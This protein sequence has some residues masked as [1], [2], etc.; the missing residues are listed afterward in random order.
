MSVVALSQYQSFKTLQRTSPIKCG[1]Y[2]CEIAAEGLT[3]SQIAERVGSDRHTVGRYLKIGRWDDE[4][5]ELAGH[6]NIS[7][8]SIIRAAS[9]PW[10]KGQ[11]IQYL[12]K[13]EISQP[14]TQ[15]APEPA[16]TPTECTESEI[17]WRYL[18]HF[19]SSPGNVSLLL[20]IFS[21]SGYLLHQGYLFFSAVDSNFASAL[22]SAFFSEAIPVVS[23]AC[24]AMSVKW[25]H[26]AL[27]GTIM[28]ATIIGVGVFMHASIHNQSISKSEGSTRYEA[29]KDAL[30][31]SILAISESI[32][33]L[34][35][36]YATKR[37]QLAEQLNRQR[38]ELSAVHANITQAVDQTQ[39]RSQIPLSY[40]AWI[41][42][43]A[44]LLN[45][46][47]VHQFFKRMAQLNI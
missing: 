45:A 29:E 27:T 40:G 36:S 7:K 12:T 16:Q 38:A 20:C 26:K 34:P 31:G 41:R 30:N 37:Q 5:K 33:A 6:E 22:S 9:R 28:M 21:F 13:G 1:E 32:N 14:A 47:L 2:L 25:S 35:S 19:V 24:L 11:L 8:T 46:F 18:R 17:S 15:K 44:M 4:V 23:A 10:D 43:A 3:Q 39:S 42:I